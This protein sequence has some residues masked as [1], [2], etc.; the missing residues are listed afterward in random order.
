MEA[1]YK[2]LEIYKLAYELSVKVHKMTFELPKHEMYEEGSQV[3]RSSKSICSNIVEGYA[4]RK[5]KNEYLHYL[6]R[7]YG[8]SEETV[9]HL[10][11]LFDTGS[12][13]DTGLYN[14]LLIAYRN[15]N[16][17]LFRFIQFIEREFKTPNFL[18]EPELNY[19]VVE[20]NQANL[21]PEP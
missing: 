20:S 14:D 13:R 9:F 16:G 6:Y 11:E 5:Y 17:K 15:L 21:N 12:L 8:S 1:G 4:L 7:A 2:K 18:K 10:E 3:R 19:N